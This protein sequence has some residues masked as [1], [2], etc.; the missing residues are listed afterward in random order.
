MEA[1]S[2]SDSFGGRFHGNELVLQEREENAADLEIGKLTE[3]EDPVHGLVVSDGGHAL[4][5]H[6]WNPPG[7]DVHAGVQNEP[8]AA[9]GELLAVDAELV[10]LPHGLEQ[11]LLEVPFHRLVLRAPARDEELEATLLQDHQT[12]E[13]LDPP[14]SSQ[15]RM[16]DHPLVNL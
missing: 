12:V 11:V 9:L 3:L 8:D 16:A 7:I 1:R 10:L 4:V 2:K 15:R 14:G 13:G 6:R 5:D